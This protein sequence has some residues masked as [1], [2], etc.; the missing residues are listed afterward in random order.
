MPWK[1]VPMSE[2]RLAFVHHVE[3]LKR[4]VADACR[5]FGISR[6]TGYKW[7]QRWRA[8][9]GLESLA[10]RS[11][12]PRHCPR[13]TEPSVEQRILEVRDRFGWGARKIRAFL[14]SQPGPS[15]PL[16]SRPTVHAVLVRN[17]RVA[18]QETP[19][20]QP[21]QSFERS[22]PNE[23]CRGDIFWH[24]YRILVGK[25]LAGQRVR[26]EQRTDQIA[27]FYHW[28]QVRLLDHA[29]LRRDTVL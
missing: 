24:N 18:L 1:V 12:R 29:Q 4:P 10:D 6:K 14:A 23:L 2:V 9:G 20:D 27:V 3:S 22:A 26:I 16:P 28:K 13:Q 8:Q 7:L 19:Q 17:Q 15:E 11:R 21:V 25:G 5:Q